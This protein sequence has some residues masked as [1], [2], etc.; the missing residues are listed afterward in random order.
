MTPA[1]TI[2][3]DIDVVFFACAHRG[4]E[5]PRSSAADVADRL[6]VNG[7]TCVGPGGQDYDATCLGQA[8]KGW[9]ALGC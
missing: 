6:E 3:R 5:S 1:R 7:R 2:D 9:L 4:R 8:S